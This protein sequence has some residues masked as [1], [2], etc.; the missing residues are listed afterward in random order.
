MNNNTNFTLACDDDQQTGA[1]RVMEH[2]FE[3]AYE[4]TCI[5]TTLKMI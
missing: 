2:I 3:I 4:S 1:N 5:V